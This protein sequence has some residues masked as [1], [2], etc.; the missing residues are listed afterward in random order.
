[1][2]QR[3]IPFI[4]IGGVIYWYWSGPYQEKVNPSYE[5]ILERNDKEMAECIRAATYK[6]GATG[7]G[8]GASAAS[9]KCA[10]DLN[11][12][13]SEGHWYSYDAVKRE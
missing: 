4:L 13:E 3:I 12:Y 10:E 9:A 1:M 11:V 8:L 7:E 5:A 6:R 2:L